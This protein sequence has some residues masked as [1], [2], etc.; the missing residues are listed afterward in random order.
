MKLSAPPSAC[1]RF[2]RPPRSSAPHQGS[3]AGATF[4][5]A[6]LSRASD[7]IVAYRDQVY[8]AFPAQAPER[9]LTS[10]EDLS[11][12]VLYQTRLSA[13]L[14]EVELIFSVKQLPAGPGAGVVAW[15]A[16]ILAVVLCAGVYLMYRLGL[17]QI[18]LARQQQD[19]VSAVSHELNTPLTSIRMYGEILREGWASEEKK[20][21]Y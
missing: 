5:E 19:F 15:L 16:G 9:Y 13:P 7:L 3:S 2:S 4:R 18:A 20:Q 14:G 11:G 6:S 1:L 17:Q 10:S 21:T 12:A 8:A